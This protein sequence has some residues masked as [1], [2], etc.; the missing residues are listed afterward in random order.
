[1]QKILDIKHIEVIQLIK[2]TDLFHSELR[3]AK[4]IFLSVGI[5]CEFLFLLSYIVLRRY[6]K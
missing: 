5:L 2:Y 4:L 6:L 3:T 1:V